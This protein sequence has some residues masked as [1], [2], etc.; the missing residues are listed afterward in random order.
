MIAV[1][2]FTQV[3][4]DGT[5]HFRKGGLYQALAVL[6]TGVVDHAGQRP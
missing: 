2:S 5:Y 1:K 4:T 6:Q 3:A